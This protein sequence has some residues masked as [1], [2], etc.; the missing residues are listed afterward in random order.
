M[1][2]TEMMVSTGHSVFSLVH[3][4]KESVFKRVWSFYLLPIENISDNV[5]G[6]SCVE[7]HY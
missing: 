2:V 4:T 7:Q 5:L 3:K 6:F 1:A